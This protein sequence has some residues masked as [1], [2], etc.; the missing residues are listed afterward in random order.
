LIHKISSSQVYDFCTNTKAQPTTSRVAMKPTTKTSGNNRQ[1]NVQ[2][3]ANIVGG[4]LYAKL[5]N[6]LKCY[7]EKICEV[8]SFVQ[9]IYIDM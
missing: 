6:H 2:D 8:R 9:V 5:K 7:L 3:G 4:E 1:T